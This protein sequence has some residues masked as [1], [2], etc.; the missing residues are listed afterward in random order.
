M[1]PGVVGRGD[2]RADRLGPE[3]RASPRRSAGCRRP[4]RRG[5]RSGRAGRPSRRAPRRPGRWRRRA[6]PGGAGPRR[7]SGRGD[8]TPTRLPTTNRRLTATLVSATFWWISLLAKR[9]SAESSAMTSASA[10]VAPVA[11]ARGQGG[12]G[13]GAAR[14]WARSSFIASPPRAY[15]LPTPT[16]TSRKRAPGT[17]CPTCPVWPGSPLPQFGVPSIT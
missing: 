1:T 10:S 9:V 3:L 4:R 14:R 6:R 13:Q 11:H 15:H 12:L 5:P 2:D 7:R 8:A 16:W 17:A